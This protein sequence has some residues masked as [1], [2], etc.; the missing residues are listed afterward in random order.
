MYNIVRI[1]HED[2]WGMCRVKSRT[3][4]RY[5]IGDSWETEDLYKRHA[6]AVP[7]PLRDGID[8][9]HDMFCAFDSME[10]FSSLVFP[11]EVKFLLTQ[12]FRVLL[13]EVRKIHPGTHQVCYRKTSVVSVKNI[14]SLF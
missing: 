7:V 12:G 10:T 9:K 3:V 2:G 1:E 5:T 4:D 14:S 11:E 8:L 13:L 6:S